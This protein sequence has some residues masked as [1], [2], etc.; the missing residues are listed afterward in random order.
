MEGEGVDALANTG[1]EDPDTAQE[2]L[3]GRGLLF[4]FLELGQFEFRL[5]LAKAKRGHS[6]LEFWKLQSSGLIGVHESLALFLS[7]PK[8]LLNSGDLACHKARII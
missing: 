7:R 5:L 1:R 3:V 2:I 6:R 8:L 4:E